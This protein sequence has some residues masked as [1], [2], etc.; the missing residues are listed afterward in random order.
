MLYKEWQSK[1]EETDT[2][3][4]YIIKFKVKHYF[5]SIYISKTFQK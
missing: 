3:S 2:V 5:I 1:R 4:L